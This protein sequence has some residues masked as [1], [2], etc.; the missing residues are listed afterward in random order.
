[1]GAQHGE[2]SRER[3]RTLSRQF[4]PQHDS[5][6]EEVRQQIRNI[7]RPSQQ[8]KFEGFLR[9]MDKRRKERESRP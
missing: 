6:C 5:I 9:D 1:M 3:Y 7:L 2:R 4:A 8:G